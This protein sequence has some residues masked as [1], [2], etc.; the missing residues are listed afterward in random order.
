MSEEPEIPTPPGRVALIT[1][2]GSKRVG[3]HI[4]KHLARR[5]WRIAIHFRTSGESATENVEELRQSGT[6]AERFQAD[7]T[8]EDEVAKLIE[9]VHGR[10]GSLD[11]AVNAAAIWKTVPLEELSADDLLRSFR[12]NTLGTFLVCRYAGLKMVEQRTG[13]AVVTF[14]DALIEHPYLDH[15]AYFVSKGAI[16]TLTRSLAVEFAARNPA[17]RV[18]SI[19]PGPILTPPGMSDEEQEV[20]RE[21][22]LVKQADSPDAVAQAVEFLLENRM[23]T[24]CTLSLDGGRNVGQEHRARGGA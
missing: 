24:G 1:G 15:A 13:G 12:V 19:A 11:A 21:S 14:G 2:S 8:R 10:F 23:L 7:L 5:G 17:V 3:Y 22:T 18:N 16:P 9:Q 4:A 20:R 6:E